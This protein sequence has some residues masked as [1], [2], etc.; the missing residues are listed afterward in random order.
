MTRVKICGITSREDLQVA[1]DA[2]ADAV[3]LLV[4]VPVET[5]REISPRRAADLAAEVPPFV[6]TVLVTMPGTP[7]RAAELVRAVNPDTVQVH[8][9]LGP[10]DL[11]YLTASVEASVVKTVDAT[12]LDRARRYDDIA[13]ALLVDSVDDDGAGG[14]GRTHDWERTRARTADLDSPVVL[15]GGLVPENVAEAVEAVD[16]F[17]VDVASGVES[18]GGRKDADAVAAFVE[19]AKRARRTPTP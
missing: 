10:G 19:N 8:G 2:G 12:E 11:A 5:P 9:D 15:A 13:D 18:T 6:S 3:G 4:D 1:V 14:T 16:P 7:D 17:A